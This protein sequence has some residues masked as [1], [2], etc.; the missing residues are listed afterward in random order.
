MKI[1]TVLACSLV[2]GLPAAAGA[3][4]AARVGEVRSFVVDVSSADQIAALHHDGWLEAKGEMVA[5]SAFPELFRAV[6]RAWTGKRVAEG[7]FTVPI[8]GAVRRSSDNPVGV[9]GPGDLVSS[10]TGGHARNVESTWIFTGRDVTA[11]L[12]DGSVLAR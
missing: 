4:D 7:H 3:A 5:T 2:L 6:G 10:G 11:A 1:I 12:Q 9:L 8:L